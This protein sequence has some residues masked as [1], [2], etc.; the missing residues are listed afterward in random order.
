METTAKDRSTTA[1]RGTTQL[2]PNQVLEIVKHATTELEGGGMHLL[3]TGIINVGAQ[4]NVVSESDSGLVMSL[5]SGR[6]LVE[7]CTFSA[8]ASTVGDGLTR[9]L[10]G[11]LETY[12][13]QQ[14]KMLIFI[15]VGPKHIDG[16]NPYKRFLRV[17]ADKIRL[18][19]P[20]ASVVVAQPE[21]C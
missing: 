13:T 6:R 11:G 5:T 3:T 9:V 2:P 7:L 15:P 10:V 20:A 4:V 21:E 12:R 18:A 17:V 1:L 14:D 8:R 19:D 16:L